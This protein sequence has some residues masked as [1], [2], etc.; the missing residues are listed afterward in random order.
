MTGRVFL[1]GPISVPVTPDYVAEA[2]DLR[3]FVEREAEHSAYHLVHLSVSFRSAP[4]LPRLYTSSV[5]LRLSSP[6]KVRAPVAWSM[7]PLRV[8]DVSQTERTFSLG[9]ELKFQDVEMTV[10][11]YEA[12]TSRTRAVPFLLGVREL[13]EDPGWEFTR[14]R[15]MSLDGSHRLVLVVRSDRTAPTGVTVTVRA[16]TRGNLLRRYKSALPKP[17]TLTAV[18]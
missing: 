14:T 1:G 6:S 18:L 13:R 2:P 15:T 11:G 17:L 3:A 12:S 9:P 16:S 8:S 10:G 4:G 7:S 5:E